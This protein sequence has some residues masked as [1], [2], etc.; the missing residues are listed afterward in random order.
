MKHKRQ[1]ITKSGEDGDGKDGG[2]SEGK[3][4]SKC[5][6][7]SCSSGGGLGLGSPDDKKSCQSCDLM[8]PSPPSPFGCSTPTLAAMNSGNAAGGSTV[9]ILNGVSPSSSSAATVD[10]NNSSYF[11]DNNNSNNGD[12]NGTSACTTMESPTTVKSSKGSLGLTTKSTTGKNKNASNNQSCNNSN[13]ELTM[14]TTSA[15]NDIHLYSGSANINSNI[16]NEFYGHAIP[17]TPPPPQRNSPRGRGKGPAASK[18]SFVH[19]PSDVPKLQMPQ[20]QLQGAGGCGPMMMDMDHLNDHKSPLLEKITNSRS[21]TTITSCAS[22]S[23]CSPSPLLNHS[24]T[25]YG[26]NNSKNISGLS[27]GG[28]LMS[29]GTAAPTNTKQSYKKKNANSSN[30]ANNSNSMFSAMPSCHISSS[31]SEYGVSSGVPNNRIQPGTHNQMSRFQFPSTDQRMSNHSSLKSA[32]CMDASN[33]TGGSTSRYYSHSGSPHSV[34]YCPSSGGS[35]LPQSPYG[36]PGQPQHGYQQDNYNSLAYGSSGGAAGGESS[37][38]QHPYG[39][40]VAVAGPDSIILLNERESV[41]GQ[42]ATATTIVPGGAPAGYSHYNS[43]GN[44]HQQHHDSGPGEPHAHSAST[45][46][47]TSNSNLPVSSQ[48]ANHGHQQHGGALYSNNSPSHNNATTASPPYASASAS[49]GGYI[50]NA[51]VDSSVAEHAGYYGG[52][53]SGAAAAV[54]TNTTQFNSVGTNST[55]ETIYCTRPN[56]SDTSA[57]M[58]DYVINDSGTPTTGVGYGPAGSSANDVDEYQQ[59]PQSYASYFDQSQHQQQHHPHHGG[60]SHPHQQHVSHHHHSGAGE[61]SSDFNFLSTMSHEY[62]PEYYQLSWTPETRTAYCK[63]SK[64]SWNSFQRQSKCMRNRYQR[65]NPK[66]I[67]DYFTLTSRNSNLAY[68]IN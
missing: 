26:K 16:K 64:C 11:K 23:T 18:K 46:Y 3:S 57:T 40:A 24:I 50:V 54:S 36:G 28:I 65:R 2:G 58:C 20:Q 13:N 37:I 53:S 44:Y 66:T 22:L 38:G 10:N 45:Y 68:T 43:Y 59:H 21:A 41:Y 12:T 15:A 51:S 35:A 17:T 62:A 29:T 34:G 1:T 8:T 63:G 33:A 19:S 39:A 32:M 4:S 61:N 52:G 67:F 25:S 27:G 48:Y 47:I 9:T 42:A 14:T 49:S 31:G 56:S 6:D 7:K 30:T 60:S 5:G 55:G